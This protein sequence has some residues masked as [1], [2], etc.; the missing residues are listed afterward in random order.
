MAV[1][2]MARGAGGLLSGVA[3]RL[4]TVG[5]PPQDIADGEGPAKDGVEADRPTC[6]GTRPLGAGDG[7]AGAAGRGRG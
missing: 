5:C 4:V 1:E 6:G 7:G 2:R 3:G